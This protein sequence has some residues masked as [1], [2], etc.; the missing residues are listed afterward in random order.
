[1][2]TKRPILIL[3]VVCLLLSMVACGGQKEPII[4]TP[5]VEMNLTA[6]DIG[7]NWSLQQEQGLNEIGEGLPKDVL[8]INVRGFLS[9]EPFGVVSSLIY[10][11]K[12]TASA[13][14][15]MKGGWLKAFVD[16]SKEQI[17]EATFKETKPP[18]IGDEA[19]MISGEG[20]F[21]GINV[22]VHS[23]IFRKSNVIVA[24]IIMGLE[25]AATEENLL[26]YAR[27]VEAK[28]H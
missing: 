14:R 17:S 23:V 13:K 7:P 24:I 3:V 25:E 5:A 15:Q 22:H 16:A 8:D 2:R 12:S 4:E 21:Q 10:S 1:M 26:E 11:T 18:S 19:T 27:K 6:A 20:S 28:I 9:M